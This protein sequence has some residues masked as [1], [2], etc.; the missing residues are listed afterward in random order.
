MKIATL[1]SFMKL[2]QLK[3]TEHVLWRLHTKINLIQILPL[4]QA[5]LKYMWIQYQDK[6]LHLIVRIQK[7]CISKREQ[8]QPIIVTHIFRKAKKGWSQVMIKTKKRTPDSFSIS[9][10]YVLIE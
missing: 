9:S 5:S 3:K 7:R 4:L 2:H 1:K 8:N 10:I 6:L